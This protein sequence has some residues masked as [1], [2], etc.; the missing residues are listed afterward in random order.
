MTWFLAALPT[1]VLVT[2]ALVVSVT[3]A[4]AGLLLVRRLIPHTVL[5]EHNDVAGFIFAVLG[6]AY[7]V[8]L[9]FVAVALWEDFTE[10][11]R[12]VQ[13]E[14]S[15]TVGIYEQAEA[16]TEPTRSHL[17][18]AIG[19]YAHLVINEE[20]PL[21]ASGHSGPQTSATLDGLW[22][23]L[24]QNEPRTQREAIWY[25]Q[26]LLSLKDLTRHREERLIAGRSQLRGVVWV[27]L[28]LGSLVTVGYT[29]LYG[30][31][32]LIGQAIMTGAMAGLLG[33][34]LA[35]VIA[36]GHPFTGPTS[37]TPDAF[38]AVLP[39]LSQHASK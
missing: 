7:A 5:R 13:Q 17:Q 4:L 25:E 29:Y 15:I 6:V 27:A 20:W 35:M 22:K 1:A 24:L 2:L 39:A 23:V 19:T 21:L 26:T 3:L 18:E 8:I 33:L 9:A 30:V 34:V 10:V 37:V 12:L 31:R 11:E 36:L 16:L 14:A 28:L 38:E 32:N